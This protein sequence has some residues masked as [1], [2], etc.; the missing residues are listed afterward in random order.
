M[1]SPNGASRARLIEFFHRSTAARIALA[2]C[3]SSSACGGSSAPAAAGATASASAS[4]PS[5][6][7]TT[8]VARAVPEELVL[9][10]ALVAEQQAMV[11][12]LVSG[13]VEAVLVERGQRV[14]AGA[15]LIRLRDAEY[16][17]QSLAA[18]ASLSQTLARLAPGSSDDNA[19][20]VL[21]AHAAASTAEDAL[22]RAEELVRDGSVSA[23]DVTRLRGEVAAARAQEVSARNA[24]RA[25]RFAAQGARA[26]LAQSE[27]SVSESL[28]RAPFAG[29][30]VERRVDAGDF[31]AAGTTV[32]RLVRA[33]ALR[34]RFSVPQEHSARVREGQTVALT[35]DALPEQRF[36]ATV[37]YV[38]PALDDAARALPVEATLANDRPNA[39]LRPGM[40]A[41][42]RLRTGTTAQ[43]VA[44]PR[45]AVRSLA[46]VARAFVFRDGRAE[47]R[48]LFV[49]DEITGDTALVARGLTA[50]ETVLLDPPETLGDGARVT[51]Q[52]EGSAR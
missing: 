50:G 24:A 1:P 30:V 20:E 45:R 8:A 51:A 3:A 49:P 27:R 52:P 21:A 26:S 25:M 9:A 32:V 37:R 44:V 38:S 36:E 2:L 12:P 31:V 4:A 40:F 42:V 5:L 13:R 39:R 29:E 7:T 43:R 28:V 33:D 10:G 18:R 46:G 14:E 6:R 35:V 48:V 47:E 23:Q 22:R 19:P 16:R 11:A 41:E 34:V 17:D 15:P